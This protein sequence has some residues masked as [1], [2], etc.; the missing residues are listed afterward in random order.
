MSSAVAEIPGRI[1][2]LLGGRTV[3]WVPE[4]RRVG[5]YE[6]RHRTL[7]IF[8]AAPGEQRE[9][10][11]RIRPARP[12]IERMLGGPL[13]VIFHTPGETERL[14]PALSR[15]HKY[16]EFAARISAWTPVHGTAVPAYDP[17]DIDRLTLEAA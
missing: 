11:R 16:R 15:V 5:D 6:G 13:I 4:S 1:S 9:L 7:E 14:Y 3:Q 8:D 12:E 2:E 17:D 10:L